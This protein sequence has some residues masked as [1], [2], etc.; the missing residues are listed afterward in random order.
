MTSLPSRSRSR[1]LTRAVSVG[2]FL[3]MLALNVLT[4]YLCDDYTYRLNFATAEPMESVL[5]ILPSMYAHSFKMNGRLISHGLAQLFMLLPPLVFD[6]VNSAVFLF[7]LLLALR[8]CG[9]K[10]RGGLLIGMFCLLWLFLLNV[11]I[12]HTPG[13]YAF[14]NE[15]SLFQFPQLVQY[16][17]TTDIKSRS[18]F[19]RRGFSHCF[20]CVKNS[21]H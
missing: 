20:Q 5:E 16:L 17:F 3:W 14:I 10:C 12:S 7:T 9:G 18:E 19:Y 4:P 11:V 21:L 2:I 15:T 13:V 6:L 8:L 1:V